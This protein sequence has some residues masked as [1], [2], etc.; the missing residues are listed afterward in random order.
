MYLGTAAPY[1]IQKNGCLVKKSIK[2]TSVYKYMDLLS[3]LKLSW[4]LAKRKL[5]LQARK[6]IFRIY[7]F[8]RPFGKFSYKEY[9]KIFDSLVMPILTYGVEIWGFEISDSKEQIHY[10]FCNDFLGLNRSSN[11]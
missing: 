2:V 6:A 7:Q 5:A 11:N 10:K 8:Q 1:A 3:T 4:Y 9:F